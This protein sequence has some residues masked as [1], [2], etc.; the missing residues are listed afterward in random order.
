TYTCASAI[1]MSTTSP[2]VTSQAGDQLNEPCIQQ[3]IIINTSM[4]LSPGTEIMINGTHFIVPSQGLGPGS[5]VLLLSSNTKQTPLP[6]AI[7]HGQ[8]QGVP[9]V[10]P[11]PLK[12]TLAP[13]N[14]L[15]WQTSKHPLKSSIK[16]VNS[17]GSA[18]ALPTVYTV[19]QILNTPASSCAS[20]STTTLSMSSVIKPPANILFAT[21][22]ISAMHPGN[23]QLSSNTSVFALDS[24]IKKLLVSPEGA[25][26]NVISTSASKAS[27]LPSVVMSTSRNPITVFPPF[28]SSCLDKPEKAAY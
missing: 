15:N 28:Q 12:I 10:N 19:P 11:V 22:L 14:S 3:K 8:R 20:L 23:S 17:S 25:I 27:S 6:L 18:N 5:H 13:T 26:R 24:S 2:P 1:Q 16:I 4:P 7:N 21:S 9:V